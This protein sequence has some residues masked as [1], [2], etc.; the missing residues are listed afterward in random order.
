MEYGAEKPSL[1]EY[2]S[3]N[4]MRNIKYAT[5][6]LLLVSSVLILAYPQ[7]KNVVELKGE[8]VPKELKDSIVNNSKKLA[9]FIISKNICSI[10]LNGIKSY[11]GEIDSSI[12]KKE[13]WITKKSKWKDKEIERQRKLIDMGVKLSFHQISGLER[14]KNGIIIVDKDVSKIIHHEKIS[15]R[16]PNSYREYIVER[17]YSA[18]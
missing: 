15:S 13:I 12:I 18:N 5:S 7:S 17:V 3:A 16:K 10:R 11:L 1:S 6:F 14:Y 2:V 8:K 4:M 9:I